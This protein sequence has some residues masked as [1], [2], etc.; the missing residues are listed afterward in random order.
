MIFSVNVNFLGCINSLM[1]RT[2]PIHGIQLF[3]FVSRHDI[4][5]FAIVL[6]ILDLIELIH[7]AKC[8]FA[9]HTRY[10]FFHYNNC[11]NSSQYCL[12]ISKKSILIL[13]WSQLVYIRFYRQC[14]VVLCK[15]NF[16]W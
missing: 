12:V 2:F 7:Q 15:N 11:H 9:L 13:F 6:M 16:R 8:F 14:L 4:P 10:R 1:I 3:M 5:V